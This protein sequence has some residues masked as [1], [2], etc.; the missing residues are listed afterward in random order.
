MSVT[1]TN[2][3]ANVILNLGGTEFFVQDFTELPGWE[4]ESY[5]STHQNTFIAENQT[6]PTHTYVPGKFSEPGQIVAEVFFNPDTVPAVGQG[7]VAQSATITFD[8]G[9]VWTFPAFIKSLKGTGEFD[10]MQMAT[11]TV[12]VAGEIVKT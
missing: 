4:R 5:R 9:S 12:T 3:A 8:S 10:G 6:I 2:I 7:D 1:R 11:L